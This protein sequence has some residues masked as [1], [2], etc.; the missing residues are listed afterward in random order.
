MMPHSLAVTLMDLPVGETC[1]W[2]GT[3]WEEDPNNKL[4]KRIKRCGELAIGKGVFCTPTHKLD[5]VLDVCERHK[6]Y[7]NDWSVELS[8]S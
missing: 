2:W 5:Y 6:Q 4:G 7:I 3:E 1:Q 8:T